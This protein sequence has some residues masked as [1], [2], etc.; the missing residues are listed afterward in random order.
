MSSLIGMQ[1]QK[2]SKNTLLAQESELTT[3]QRITL[4]QIKRFIGTLWL[5]SQSDIPTFVVPNTAF[6]IFG[7]LSGSQMTAQGGV[8]V[9]Q[10]MQRL[11]L[12]ILFN[13]SNVFIFELANQR[14]PE[15]VIED[16]INKPWRPLPTGR[17]SPDGTRRLMLV[18]IIAVFAINVAMGVWKETALLFVLT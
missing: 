7:A 5:F 15:S 16:R 18:A 3:P 8:H 10:I 11:P 14:Q 6:G 9:G 13:W 17:I 2:H 12:V 1:K 4:R